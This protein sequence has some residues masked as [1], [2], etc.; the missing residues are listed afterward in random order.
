[1]SDPLGM[2]VVGVTERTP[3]TIRTTHHW[4]RRKNPQSQC[5]VVRYLLNVPSPTEENPEVPRE[6]PEPTQSVQGISPVLMVNQKIIYGPYQTTQAV[7]AEVEPLVKD[8]FPDHHRNW[9]WCEECGI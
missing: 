6:L 7:R 8:R 9:V 5:S 3:D 1:M 2:E 4:F